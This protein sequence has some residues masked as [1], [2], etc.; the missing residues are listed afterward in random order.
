M[1]NLAPWLK[2]RCNW[3][4][5]AHAGW[6]FAGGLLAFEASWLAIWGAEKILSPFSEKTAKILL[7][8]T[9]VILLAGILLDIWRIVRRSLVA[10][11][12]REYGREHPE[13]HDALEA[14]L[15]LEAKARRGPLRPFE[16][17][18]LE[19][20]QKRYSENGFELLR[21]S[22][23]FARPRVW[24]LA[25]SAILIA[26]FI[27]YVPNPVRQRAWQGIV[28]NQPALE[29][30]GL[31]DEIERH[32]D[33]PVTARINRHGGMA[34]LEVRE[35][36]MAEVNYPM[37][38]EGT[39]PHLTIY[40]VSQD[41]AIRV[42]TAF[43][44]SGWHRI[45]VY[46]P[47]APVRIS[48]DTIPP[49]YTG[50]APQHRDDFGDLELI[51]GEV[52]QVQCEMPEGQPCQLL[53]LSAASAPVPWT[54][55]PGPSPGM[56]LQAEYRDG[57]GHIAHGPAFAV[58]VR[59]DL[60]PTIELIEPTTETTCKPGETP[61]VIA[62]VTDDFGVTAV[63]AHFYLDNQPERTQTL[64]AE[65]SARPSSQ[66]A[67]L[68]SPLAVADMGLAPGQLL[69]GWLEAADNCE[70]QANRV[71]SELFFVTVV[72][73][74]NSFEADMEGMDGEETH[75]V[76]IS[77]LIVESKRLL[78]NTFDLL[79]LEMDEAVAGR[80]RQ[81]LERDL[82]ALELAVRS[83]SV[84][85]ASQLGMSSLPKELQYFFTEAATQLTQ[86]AT[87]VTAGAVGDSRVPQQ[88][89]LVVLV[90]LNNILIE[91]LMKMSAKG[92]EGTPEP[93]MDAE[94]EEGTSP[95]S[96]PSLE[97]AVED[98][99][100]EIAQMEKAQE[101][102]RGILREQ[103]A[104]LDD[105][106]RAT[107]LADTYA[108]PERHL[109]MRARNVGGLLSGIA[110]AA[111]IQQLLRDAQGELEDAA[112]NFAASGQSSV[113]AIHARRAE[114]HLQ[115]SLTL[116]EQLLQSLTTRQIEKLSEDAQ[117]LSERQRELSEQ[118]A[119][120]SKLPPDEATRQNLRERQDALSKETENLR[121]RIDR[122]ARS[123]EREDPS[124]AQQLRS[125]MDSQSNSALQRSQS[126]ARNALLYRRYGTAS[127]E[128]KNAA[129]ELQ[130]VADRLLDAAAQT[131]MS[132]EQLR[133]AME[134]IQQLAD[135]AVAS[136]DAEQ[137]AQIGE[138]AAALIQQL[139]KQLGNQT[140]QDIAQ[141]L[142]EA[143]SLSDLETSAF[144]DE[145]M[146]RL[147]AAGQELYQELLQLKGNA[148]RRLPPVTAPPRQYRQ[149]VEEYFRRL[150][151]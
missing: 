106:R 149:E 37:Q 110:A 60:A 105:I 26:L 136:Q 78:R 150:G 21:E 31:P 72:P 132:E 151:E 133:A 48:I 108:A 51:A 28:S 87:D 4:R 66:L 39:E 7:L 84:D 20:L 93:G 38:G 80:L 114:K 120:H 64:W 138:Q 63:E 95:S 81:E 59:P 109:A 118:S 75:K 77:D 67:E 17:E 143:F 97:S 3:R 1:A 116:L 122:A 33:L 82:R 34:T 11:K 30:T 91:N 2:R 83:R 96:E 10:E 70:P 18:Y 102:L 73:D 61:V 32:Q 35:D 12:A 103:H 89:A 29:F 119:Q 42:R 124:G 71:R 68:T 148:P 121:Q 88:S 58:T 140:L 147:E 23:A 92:G 55:G 127:E 79:N 49:A 126:R 57:A 52:L 128:Q 45:A 8:G 85:L 14:A 74:E 86:A 6:L 131:G 53:E 101:E 19:Q 94:D 113:A 16:Q 135:E 134:A 36:G 98:H 22:R 125:A 15:E 130:K 44:E 47:P 99:E 56:R 69:T 5:L 111:P 40:D 144:H 25:L 54:L 145:L 46:D 104:V 9:T 27:L 123:M 65:E 141:E 139:G 115:D 41:L 112:N 43:A 90:Q 50:R 13:E 146:E 117:G 62:N 24:P 129:D 142:G 100:Q 137:L 107:R 76:D